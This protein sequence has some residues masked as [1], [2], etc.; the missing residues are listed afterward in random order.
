MKASPNLRALLAALLLATVAGAPAVLAQTTQFDLGIGYQWLDVSGNEDVYRT[1]VKEKDGALLDS[2]SVTLTEPDGGLF[3]RLTLDAAGIGA[4][5]DAR[6]RIQANRAGAYNLRINYF[7]ADVFSALPGY[8]NPFVSSGVIPGQHTFDR[9]RDAFDLDLELL[10][11]ATIS[12]L[13]GLSRQ[14]YWGPGST[15][16]HFGQDEFALSND[17]DETTMEYRLGVAFTVGAWRATVL[18]GWRNVDSSYDYQLSEAPTAGNNSRPVL[19]R[20]IAASQL[21]GHSRTIASAPFTNA[22]V[23]GRLGNRLRIA[24]SYVRS[25]GA[26]AETDETFT[27]R[28]QFAS[29]ALARFFQGASDTANGDAASDG[30]RGNARIEFAI[31]EWLDVVA[32]VTSAERSLSGSA[33]VTTNYIDTIN[34]SGVSTGNLSTL[35]AADTAWERAEDYAEGKFVVRPAK[36]LQFW[37]GAGSLDQKVTITPAAA[38]IVVPGGQ[39]GAF[40]RSIDR[41]SAGADAT[42]GPVTL[43]VDW[44]S[45]DADEAFVRTDYLDRERLRARAGVKIGSMVK[46]LGTA[47]WI[48]LDNPTP[49]IE[50]D[51]EIEH[52]A[53]T[54]EVTPVAAFS[55]HASYDT[56]T[57]DSTV[58]IRAPQDFSTSP[59]IYA[60]DGESIDGGLTLKLGRV[61]LDAGAS[62]YSNDGDLPFD[63]DRT[64]GRIDVQIT[65]AIGVYGQYESREYSETL[66]PVAD[67]S[68][69]R[70]GLFLRWS[71]Q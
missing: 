9:R 17:L 10:P 64:Y 55:L 24:G 23:T 18:Q 68:A 5:P 11:G 40:E 28:G 13:V 37:A 3:D 38:E 46:L 67:Y 65:E 41:L 33:L 34:F 61:R 62:R 8:A 69:D 47:E 71:S 32:G 60:E 66:L 1:Q 45:D 20:D 51:A 27:A 12:P 57:S 43:G 35:L 50:Y 21:A 48:D 22:F 14:H 59:S 26:D 6:F 39:G 54:V 63:L 70:Y 2:L 36:W 53:A 31:T 30:W 7:R 52:L 19:G 44:L 56:Y 42:L 49:G 58:L 25:N 29:F 4:S 15:T 16:Y